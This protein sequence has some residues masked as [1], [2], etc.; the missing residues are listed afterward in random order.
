MKRLIR[1]ATPPMLARRLR[2]E[3]ER[4][5]PGYE[6][7]P[8]ATH[9]E[10]FEA[11]RGF[12]EPGSEPADILITA[13][14]QM[15]ERIWCDGAA[16]VDLSRLHASPLRCEWQATGMTPPVPTAR[17]VAV[18]PL[19]LAVNRDLAPGIRDWDDLEPLLARPRGLGAPPVDTP[20][21]FLL[22]AYLGARWG[23]PSGEVLAGFDCASPPLDINKRLS[24]GELA[25]GLLPPAFCRN[26][27]EGDVAL[28]WPASGAL[29][30]PMVAAV[31]PDAPP[32]AIRVLEF[33][34]SPEIQA[35][36]AEYGGLAPATADATGFAELEVAEWR[37]L[38][39]GWEAFVDIGRAMTAH[40][41]PSH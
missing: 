31:A 23:R 39:P 3:I 21:P 25:A 26:V 8:P 14:P 15:L 29:A 38:W 22:A 40:L 27:R 19:V 12:G 4:A 13:Y 30:V 17:I 24:R 33:L 1:F 16:A 35:T 34:L 32:D 7:S 10:M 11:A 20:L 28:V 41:A 37:V 5:F 2:Q 18:V 9:L 6:L 36:F